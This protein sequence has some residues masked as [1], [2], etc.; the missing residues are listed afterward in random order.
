MP[1]PVAS[2]NFWETRYREAGQFLYGIH[3]NAYL[4]RQAKCLPAGGTALAVADGEGRN[5]VW[6]AEQGLDVLSVDGSPTALARAAELAGERGVTLRTAC[7]SLETWTWPRGEMDVV[8]SVFAHFEPDLRRSVHPSMI[9]ALRPGGLVILQGFG[10]DQLAY[11]SGGP[12][13]LDMLFTEAMLREDFAGLEIVELT[14]YEDDLDERPLHQGR[15]ALVGMV[16][17]KSLET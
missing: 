4:A 8:V 1:D 13:S 2:E 3:P 9:D 12:R 16:A 11:D 14:S 5:G 15:A 17:Q 6:L 10:A 7:A